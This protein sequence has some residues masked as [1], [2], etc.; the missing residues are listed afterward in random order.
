MKEI[1]VATRNEYKRRQF[2]YLLQDFNAEVKTLADFDFRNKVEENGETPRENALLKARFWAG[3]T[4]LLTIGDDAGLHIDAL[5]GEPG[6]QARRW[7][8]LFEDNV[9]DETWLNYLLKRME[10][11]PPEKRTARWQAA[12][13][14]VLPDGREFI[15]DIILKFLILEKPVRPYIPGSPMSALRFFPEYKKVETELSE[16]EQWAGLLKEIRD[17]KELTEALR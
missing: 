6:L 4:G 13:A 12:W 10:G 9:D 2:K 1:L 3:K 8:G 5:A 17:W 15:K 11:V 7:N 16:E 14:L